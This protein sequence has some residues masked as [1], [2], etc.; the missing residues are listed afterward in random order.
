MNPFD[1]DEFLVHLLLTREV[2][3]IYFEIASGHFNE[4][5]VRLLIK[6]SFIHLLCRRYGL[7][8]VDK[9]SEF[10]D[11]FDEVYIFTDRISSDY[12]Q[13][14]WDR[15]YSIRRVIEHCGSVKDYQLEKDIFLEYPSIRLSYISK[16][17]LYNED[18]IEEM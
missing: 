4:F 2:E 17:F 6:P 16:K 12:R 13:L 8:T 15:N 11:K 9:F 14:R 3:D 10:L 5:T 7:F 18:F 1:I